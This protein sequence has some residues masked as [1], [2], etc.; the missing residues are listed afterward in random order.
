[1]FVQDPEAFTQAL[2]KIDNGNWR[3]NYRRGWVVFSKFAFI[4]LGLKLHGTGIFAREEHLV[5]VLTF[6]EYMNVTL[7]FSSQP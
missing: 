6:P 1:M 4:S 3:G 7:I 2:S 5:C